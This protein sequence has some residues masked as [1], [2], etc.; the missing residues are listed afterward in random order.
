M[1]T[2]LTTRYRFLS[3][4]SSPTISF[5]VDRILSYIAVVWA[6]RGKS[7]ACYQDTNSVSSVKS[8]HICS[9]VAQNKCNLPLKE[10]TSFVTSKAV[11]GRPKTK[12]G[13]A[14]F[15]ANLCRNSGKQSG[16]G[17]GFA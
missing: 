16:K 10:P 3:L 8:S 6:Q 1:A 14:R 7:S 9:L 15:K 13:Q 12:E 17:K 5:N 2:A 4:G 11:H